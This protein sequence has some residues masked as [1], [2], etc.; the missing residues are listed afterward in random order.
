VCTA[1]DSDVLA[2]LA[3]YI[4]HLPALRP[5]LGPDTFGDANAGIG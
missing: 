5:D 2:R 1:R 4:G 3:Q